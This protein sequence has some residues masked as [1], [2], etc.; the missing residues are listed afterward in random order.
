MKKYPSTNLPATY[1]KKL[2]QTPHGQEDGMQNE[3][4]YTISTL[5]LFLEF[6]LK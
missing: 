1:P 6:L 2:E 5:L 4:T 3:N